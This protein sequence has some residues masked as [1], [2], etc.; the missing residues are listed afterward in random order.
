[1]SSS[2]PGSENQYLR[3]EDLP[4]TD[5]KKN[6]LAL[7]AM[8]CSNIGADIL[9]TGKPIVNFERSNKKSRSEDSRSDSVT[10]DKLQANSTDS[11]RSNSRGSEEGAK[12]NNHNH[13]NNNNINKSSSSTPAH[14]ISFKPYEDLPP[15]SEGDRKDSP[16]GKVSPSRR[17]S[18]S[19]SDGG[20]S[21]SNHRHHE[22]SS[23]VSSSSSHQSSS[24]NHTSE[25]VNN[26]TSSPA[27]TSTGPPSSSLNPGSFLSGHAK[28]G[29]ATC[30]DPYC[31]GCLSGLAAS[32]MHHHPSSSLTNGSACCPSF[33]HC[34]HQQLAA[35]YAFPGHPAAAAASLA[36]ASSLGLAASRAFPN[37]TA[38]AARPF[39]CH[40][41]SGGSYCGKSFTS[42]EELLQH[43]KT[44][45]LTSP[46]SSSAASA[47][48]YSPYSG[49]PS[50]YP[51]NPFGSLSSASRAS[52]IDSLRYHPYKLAN[53]Y[54]SHMRPTPSST[55]LLSPHHPYPPTAHHPSAAAN[56]AGTLPIFP[57]SPHH[58]PS[59][60]FYSSLLNKR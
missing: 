44:H 13:H 33:P 25:H 26:K 29:S 46:S 59:L 8:T 7:L 40:W 58:H 20:K 9:G 53:S 30:R 52:A 23:K 11:N 12:V 19:P 10:S 2:G 36:Y 31:P 18:S 42:C 38:A 56:P 28:G 55:P 34:I 54:G 14:K 50:P 60:G 49:L 43:L 45:T 15:K 27:S 39:L 22:S 4:I 24:S 3:P 57:P 51:A 1:M 21:L 48:P 32:L 16:R 5:A 41:T 37:G 47:S 6:P 17:T 35:A